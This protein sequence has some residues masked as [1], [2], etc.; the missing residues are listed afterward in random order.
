MIPLLAIMAIG[1]AAGA[2]VGGGSVAL[3]KQRE[4]DELDRQKKYAKEA[5]G[6]KTAYGQNMYNLQRG[7]ALETL[8]IARNRLADAFDMDVAGFNLGLEGQ[9]LQNQDARIS[10]A[11][12]AGMALAAQGASGARGS[13]SLQTR[14]DY[15]ETG[16]NR[17]MD[18][19][20]RGNSLAIQNMAK[21]YSNQFADIGR[22]I[23]SWGPG[24]YRYRANEL[25]KT[26]ERQ[27]HGLQM[28]GY[29]D[30]IYDINDPRY[31]WMDYLTG[32]FGGAGQGANFGKKVGQFAAQVG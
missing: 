22:E 17:Q 12:S 13:D 2:A 3:N 24:G 9:A 30:A 1:A 20:D 23:D 21:Q 26:Y 14:L 27:M 15:A 25:S 28:Q 8:G 7:E 4:K 18:L 19:Q 10:L 11:D 32:I 16:L 6:Y 29:D 5:Y 31:A